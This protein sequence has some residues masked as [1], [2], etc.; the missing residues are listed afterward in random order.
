MRSS[1][2]QV[3]KVALSAL[4]VLVMVGASA[5]RNATADV[6]TDW[7]IIA[8]NAT[9]APPNSILQSRVLA[10][11]HGAIYDTVRAVD[12]KGDTYA[13][14]ATAA[15]GASVD[16]AVATTA[17]AVLVRLAPMQRPMLDAALNGTLAKI[18]DGQDKTDGISIGAQIA[19]KLLALRQADGADAKVAFT[20]K[21]GP[22]LYQLTPP[23]NL[24]AILPHWGNVTPFVLRSRSGLEF[25]GPPTIASSAFARDF[26]EVKSIGA[27]NSATRTA[28]QTAAAIFWTVQTAV[29]W[30]AAARAAS[31]TK[32]LSIT[33]NARLFA[34]LSMATADSQI[35][36]FD[37]KYKRPFWRP[38]TAIRAA[39][40]LDI[41]GLKG[42]PDWEPLTVTPPQPDYPSAHC[43]FSGAAEAVLRAF[44]GS[45]E[46]NVSVTAPGP[47]GVTR[48]YR[49]F[50][51]MTQEVENAR[52]WSGIHFRTADRDGVEVGRK[53]GE[54]VMREFPNSPY[55]STQIG[56]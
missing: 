52:V 45:D 38:I 48:T 14:D 41:P 33:E 44:F 54:I 37:E 35:I 42:D 27:R 51:E 24:P 13:V 19:E 23:H 39:I 28:D 15:P 47:F 21:P 12:R 34:L 29:P 46:V 30:H 49:K 20:P 3:V 6:V 8:L 17:H 9:A 26:E 7:N 18:A 2:P 4:G 10:V 40:D 25:K 55:R 50:S 36:A 53:I 22:G 43:I 5:P 16:A 56:R 31:I 32:Q 1:S 11:V